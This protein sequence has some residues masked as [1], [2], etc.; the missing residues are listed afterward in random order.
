MLGV[1]LQARRGATGSMAS[2]GFES[3]GSG[4]AGVLM[5][6][7][8]ALVVAVVM[9]LALGLRM[10]VPAMA[11]SGALLLGGIYAWYLFISRSGP[12]SDL[13]FW[14]LLTGGLCVI[15]IA[16]A[17]LGIK[18]NFV[19]ELVLFAAAPLAIASAWKHLRWTSG[20]RL[21]IT[22]FLG[23]FAWQIFVSVFGRSSPVAASYQLL[24]NL[25]PFLLL[26]LGFSLC[27]STRTE[28]FF[29]FMVR[30][31]WL[32]LG[33]FVVL[34]IVSPSTYLTY[35]GGNLLVDRTPNPLLPFLT[36]MQGPFEHSSVLATFCVQ[37]SILATCR[38]WLKKSVIDALAI[39][40]YLSLA[41]LSGQRQE[42]F[43]FVVVAILLFISVRFRLGIVRLGLLAI[44]GSAIAVLVLWPVLGEN[45]QTEVSLWRQSG[46]VGSEGVR[47]ALYAAAAGIA[48]DYAPL[49][50][51]L[52]TFGGPASV[53]FD[54][55]L[56]VEM[57]L[58]RFWWFQRGLFL[59]DSIWACY[60][61][62][63][64]WFGAF[65]L[66]ALFV[67]LLAS[68]SATYRKAV[69]PDD[70]LFALAALSTMAYAML[71]SP[72]AFVITDPVTGLMSFVFFGLAYRRVHST[73]A[74]T[75]S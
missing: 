65:W 66:F 16:G 12:Q 15:P 68:A 36:R 13:P 42:I 45:F 23:Y 2:A 5:V 64:G 35:F 18:A 14:L 9:G 37:L 31:V 49:G 51:G 71:V 28:D 7:M 33:A 46:A 24:T 59:M 52:G 57:G 40:P 43:V 3:A 11:L 61:A 63:L 1:G 53:R 58:G 8:G 22:L 4:A 75:V 26:L 56:Y 69:T 60:I 50:S 62:E 72:T 25:K 38:A 19:A 10:I 55:S 39:A 34:Q 21:F 32:F 17:I 29:W 6:V 44:V 54:Q 41:L 30:W 48:N 20:E 73:S 74:R 47:S 67:A 70:R 27:W